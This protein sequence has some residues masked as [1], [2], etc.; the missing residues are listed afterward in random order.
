MRRLLALIL[1]AGSLVMSAGCVCCHIC[2]YNDCGCDIPICGHCHHECNGGT[3]GGA[4]VG[5]EVVPAPVGPAVGKGSGNADGSHSGW[6]KGS[7]STLP[8]AG[9]GSISFDTVP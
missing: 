8:S 5:H 9:S 1:C 3:Y 2:G 6:R 4:V 7:G